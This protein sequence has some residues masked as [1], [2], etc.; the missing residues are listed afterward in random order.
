MERFEISPWFVYSPRNPGFAAC[1]ENDLNLLMTIHL[2]SLRTIFTEI[3]R[4][5]N[6][7]QNRRLSIHRM[8]NKF[9]TVKLQENDD[10]VHEEQEICFARDNRE[11]GE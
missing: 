3:S 5:A 7:V 10:R 6:H 8:K 4:A 2:K 11:G 9:H 1:D